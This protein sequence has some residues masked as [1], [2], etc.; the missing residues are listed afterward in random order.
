MKIGILRATKNIHVFLHESGAM[1]I[2]LRGIVDE[3]RLADPRG[4]LI[5]DR[6]DRK[7]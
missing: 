3:F 1:G 5:N 2:R 6:H 4:F 7:I